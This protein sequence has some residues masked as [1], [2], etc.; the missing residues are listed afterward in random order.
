MEE[1]TEMVVGENGALRLALLVEWR[2]PES[3]SGR[4]CDEKLSMISGEVWSYVGP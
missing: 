3:G 1:I 2:E 4:E